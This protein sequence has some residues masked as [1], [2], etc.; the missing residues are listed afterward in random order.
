MQ[1][2]YSFKKNSTVVFFLKLLDRCTSYLFDFVVMI[3]SAVQG[4]IEPRR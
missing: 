3:I 1:T 4:G 2:N